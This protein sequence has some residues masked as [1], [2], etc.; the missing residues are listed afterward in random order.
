M[1]DG[2]RYRPRRSGA[3]NS[4][5]PR[6]GARGRRL[7]RERPARASGLRA[8]RPRP[9]VSRVPAAMGQGMGRAQDLD[10]APRRLDPV[11]PD[12][13]ARFQQQPGSLERRDRRLRPRRH[14]DPGRR[15]QPAVGH[16]VDG[17]DPIVINL[18]RDRGCGPAR[19]RAPPESGRR[20]EGSWAVR[21]ACGSREPRRRL[22]A[23]TS[24]ARPRC[25]ETRPARP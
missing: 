25:G 4:S 15:E 23:A 17:V 20:R 8:P 13:P 12:P 1:P 9:V 14:H 11:D 5:G 6:P 2:R 22:G 18:I 19:D 24:P 7:D 3:C 10:R 16:R 21:P